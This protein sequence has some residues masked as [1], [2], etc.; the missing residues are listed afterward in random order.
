VRV[1]P[2]ISLFLCFVCAI[3]SL[4]AAMKRLTHSFH[5]ER[6]FV[7]LPRNETWSVSN[8]ISLEDVRQMLSQDF[9]YLSRGSQSFVFLSQDR[10]V[11]LKLF[12]FDSDEPLMNR[13]LRA[14]FEKPRNDAFFNRV[15]KKAIQ[16]MEASK[17]AY[18]Y[19]RNETAIVYLHLNPGLDN[20]PIV[21]LRG[22][23]W[24]HRSVPI[25][26]FRFVL[27]KRA[28]S[29]NHSLLE[30][31]IYQDSQRFFLLIDRLNALL[32]HRL[33]R[34]IVN[35]DPTLFNNFGVICDQLVEID[36]GNYIYFPE[37]FDPNR[38]AKEKSR[39]YVHLL[40][41]V[42]QYTPAWKD[43]VAIRINEISERCF[44]EGQ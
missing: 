43:D 9:D 41:W 1:L 19:L 16:T 18:E 2:R 30:A 23:A 3:L 26:S 35:T 27:Q 15:Q 10:S 6:L 20:L 24:K 40:K 32:D 29:L 5:F 7:E 28:N 42:E 38:A 22:P 44:W 14:L 13:L 4:P 39:Y 11:V 17:L 31:Y 33:A 12:L 21:N 25:D 36:F 34:S 8:Q 37:F